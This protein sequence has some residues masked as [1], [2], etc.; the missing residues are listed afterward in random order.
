MKKKRNADMPTASGGNTR[1]AG[2]RDAYDAGVRNAYAQRTSTGTNSQKDVGRNAGYDAAGSRSSG[3]TRKSSGSYGVQR[4]T[5][6]SGM[7]NAPSILIDRGN[8]DYQYKNLPMAGDALER[9][10]VLELMVQKKEN[11]FRPKE[12]ST[13]AAHDKQVQQTVDTIKDLTVQ[14]IPIAQRATSENAHGSR[15]HNRF[16]QTL[17][18]DEKA[19]L[20][21]LNGAGVLMTVDE[22]E[23]QKRRN[24]AT[25]AKAEEELRSMNDITAD[26]LDGMSYE[27]YMAGA[28]AN[29]DKQMGLNAV[30]TGAVKGNKALDRIAEYQGKLYDDD[31]AGQFHA[32]YTDSRLDRDI[33]LAYSDFAD[34]MS[35]QN[36]NYVQM[37]EGL[38]GQMQRNNTQTLDDDVVNAG[39][40]LGLARDIPGAW[41]EAKASAKGA[42]LGLGI[43]AMTQGL[44]PVSKAMETG[45]D[46]AGD[47][48]KRDVVRGST[49]RELMAMGV[50]AEVAKKAA[51]SE[52][53][54]SAWLDTRKNVFSALE[55]DKYKDQATRNI[56]KGIY[57]KMEDAPND[58]VKETLHAIVV[59]NAMDGGVD[60][61][62]QELYKQAV[63]ESNFLLGLHKDY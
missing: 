44:I 34:D 38:Q 23:A 41:D 4:S 8:T 31:A 42:V 14:N 63:L 9:G 45:G 51:D 18:D 24:D 12:D 61:T 11:E 35:E 21:E 25:R 59:Q 16:L 1:T 50:D 27:D 32:N 39:M 62:P 40:S 54:V 33:E 22:I 26:D 49:L 2:D 29:L 46:I 36:W 58:A 13:R 3:G 57:S 48:Y 20:R 52:A 15:H 6:R 5:V 10:A 60:V 56:P 7:S 19:K 37:L 17:I 28:Q 53:M 43:S 30:V 55:N 47:A